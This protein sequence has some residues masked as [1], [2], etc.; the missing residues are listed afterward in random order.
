MCM[1]IGVEYL[2]DNA[3]MMEHQ[4]VFGS[5]G[6]HLTKEFYTGYWLKNLVTTMGL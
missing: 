4:D 2:S 6:L 1:E 5:D 3:Y